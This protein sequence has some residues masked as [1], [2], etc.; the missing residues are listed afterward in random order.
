MKSVWREYANDREARAAADRLRAG[1]DGW[2]CLIYLPR[3]AGQAVTAVE[4][5]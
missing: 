3:A 4:V 5:G 2:Q 1:K